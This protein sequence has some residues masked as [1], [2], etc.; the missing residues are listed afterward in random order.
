[1]D[2]VEIIVVDNG[3]NESPTRTCSQFSNV[4]L[5]QEAIPGPG[6]ARNKGT[7]VSHGAILAFID[8]DCLADEN[9]LATI[10]G[11]L[12]KTAQIIGGDVRIALVDPHK[13][14]MLEAYES[15]FAYRQ[16][17][18]I[19]RQGFSGTGNLAMRRT[20]YDTVGAFAGIEIAEDRDWGRRATKLGY[21]ISY[22]SDML[23][24]HPAR[25]SFD[26]LFSK[27]DRIIAHDFFD[28]SQKP[29]GR[30]RWAFRALGVAASPV[31]E[32]RRILTSSRASTWRDRR[33][34]ILGLI[35]IRLYR[36]CRM[37]MVLWKG[38]S[39]SSRSWNVF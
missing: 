34:A 5:E 27:W 12:D 33:L 19:E 14:T 1:M 9:W 20:V 16:Q 30:L 17:D 7:I 38:A 15:I 22:L 18:Y 26:E 2:L 11:A 31:F 25:R 6:P 23:V 29:A 10:A 24:F 28:Y 3:S 35:R 13:A 21:S 37:L 8:A 4:Q 32:I 36:A 39:V